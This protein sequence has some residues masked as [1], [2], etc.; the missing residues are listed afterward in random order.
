MSISSIVSQLLYASRQE[1]KILFVTF[2]SLANAVLANLLLI[3]L[4]KQNGAAAA[5]IITRFIE[6]ILYC[7]FAWTLLK[8]VFTFSLFKKILFANFLFIFVLA[9]LKIATTS[10]TLIPRLTII[11]LSSSIAYGLLSSLLRLE[12]YILLKDWIVS[13][14]LRKKPFRR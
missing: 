11:L 9:G 8:P 2:I 10:M 4:F 12:P 3:P 13:I 7:V 14:F 5:T 6:T 1:K